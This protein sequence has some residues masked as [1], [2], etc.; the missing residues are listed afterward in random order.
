MINPIEKGCSRPGGGS[1][2]K[3]EDFS[4][5]LSK[6]PAA[7]HKG[8]FGRLV[9]AVGSYGMAGAAVLSIKAALRCGV[10]ICHGVVPSGIYPTVSAGVPEAVFSVYCGDGSKDA[11][12]GRI[13]D[14]ET[15]VKS[16]LEK[17]SAFL[18]GCGCGQC[19]ATETALKTAIETTDR[20]IVIDADGINILCSHINWLER[21]SGE[22]VLTPHPGEAARLL[23]TD[24]RQIESDRNAAAKEISRKYRAVTVLK[25]HNTVICDND[26]LF[27]NPTGNP[28]MATGGSGDVLAGMIGSFISQG[29][30]VTDAVKTAVYLH[31]AAGDI[32]ARRLSQR[33]C[34]PSDIIDALPSLFLEFENTPH[35]RSNAV[36]TKVPQY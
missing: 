19:K 3:P 7:S 13:L 4:R 16:S 31:G 6:R 18:I 30:P 26:K 35:S 11:A 29:I 24:V 21:H 23:H 15:A 5:Y 22:V 8:D 14:V 9:C 33:A 12:E 2:I 34:L 32:A 20:P 17:A 36:D 27:I 28:G 25:G 1:I 10:G